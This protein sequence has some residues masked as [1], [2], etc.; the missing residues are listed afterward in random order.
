MCEF[1]FI[2]YQ[3]KEKKGRKRKKDAGVSGM[4]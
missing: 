3:K 1:E 4:A 2:K